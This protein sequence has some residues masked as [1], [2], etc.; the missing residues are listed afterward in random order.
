VLFVV[1]GV[2]GQEKEVSE[3]LI[4]ES[5]RAREKESSRRRRVYRR[6]EALAQ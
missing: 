4:E 6:H 2:A 3:R 5:V 1:D